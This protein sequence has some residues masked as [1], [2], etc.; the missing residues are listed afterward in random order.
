MMLPDTSSS[1]HD[2]TKKRTGFL[3]PTFAARLAERLATTCDVYCGVALQDKG[4]AFAKW[5]RQ[6]P[7]LAEE[8]VT[9]GYSKTA[10]ALSGLWMDIDVQG[11]ALKAASLPPS[12]GAA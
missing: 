7:D 12:K 2:R 8:P 6:N 4:A 1:G 9:R 11:P 10:V 5:R 3:R